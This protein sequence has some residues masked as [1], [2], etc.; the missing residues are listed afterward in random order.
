MT[1]EGLGLQNKDTLCADG[2]FDGGVDGWLPVPVNVS[3]VGEFAALL[4]NE[5]LPEA[6][7]AACGANVIVKGTLCP[8]IT[9]TGK[10]IPLTENPSPLQLP[11]EIVTAELLAAS[12]RV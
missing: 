4:R 3:E 8:A 6:E 9:V 12:W 7:P 2:G 10:V 11:E 1:A 5:M